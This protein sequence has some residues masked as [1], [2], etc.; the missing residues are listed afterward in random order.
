MNE[1]KRLLVLW[2][3][4]RCNLKCKYC[5]A[6][7]GPAKDM[8]MDTFKKAVEL[9]GAYPFKIQFAGGE[10]L[11]NKPL[12]EEILDYLERERPD[13]SCAIQTNGTLIDDSFARMVKRHRLA[14][15][16]SMDGKPDKNEWLRG[17]TKAV[18]EGVRLLGDYGISLN[19]N[20]VVTAENVLHLADIVD[21]AVYFG[22]VRGIGLDLLRLSGRAMEKQVHRAE[23]GDLEEG[24][25]LLKERLDTVN[26]LLKRPLVVREFQKAA[27]YLKTRNVCMDY[28]F[29][30]QGNSFVVLPDGEC[31]PCGSLAGE[32][33][34]NMGNVHSAVTPIRINCT[35]PPQCSDCTYRSVCSGGCP[36]R[37]LLYGGFDEL[38]CLMKKI[39]FQFAE[40]VREKGRRANPFFSGE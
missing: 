8:D 31:Y 17:R 6:A 12:L 38:D 11:L 22:N 5:Y 20:T 36:S 28:C 33:K 14:V 23:P 19:L 4:G 13:V 16:V 24:L 1:G 25:H 9:M 7:H 29:A 40:D 15:G 35:R 27:Y 21:M 32:K 3:T 39:T 34:Y 2:L 26:R 37:G 30:S 18:I 10:P